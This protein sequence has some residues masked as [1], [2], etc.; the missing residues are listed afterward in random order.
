[1]YKRICILFV[2]FATLAQAQ[3]VQRNILSKQ[4]PIKNFEQF[5]VPKSSYHPYPKTIEEW[6]KLVPDSILKI[7]VKNGE[8]FLNFKF[9]PIPGSIAMEFTRTG[10]RQKQETISFKKR[11]ALFS[12]ILAESI[13]NKNRFTEAIF[14]GVWSIC[15]ES[16]WGAAAHIGG[17]GLPDPTNPVVELFSAETASVLALTDYFVGEKLDKINPQIRR[18][19]YFETNRRLLDPMLTIGGS[20]KWMS[21][22]EPVN[23][24]N[25]WII[26]NWITAILLLENDEKKRTLMAHN[27]MEGLDAYINGLGEEGGCDEGPSYWFAAGASVYD[28][29][30]IFAGA[31]NNKVK[32][33]EEPLIKKMGGYIYKMH[34][35]KNYFVNF[36]DADPTVAADGIMLYRFGKAINDQQM[37]GFGQWAFKNYPP[38]F[39]NLPTNTFSCARRIQ[40]LMSLQQMNT[41]PLPYVA[42]TAAWISDIQVLTART[43][44]GLFLATHGGHNAESHNHNDVGDF[45][46]YGNDEPIIIDAGR[47][48]YTARTF[49]SHRYELWFT[50][51]NYHNLPLVNNY[52]QSA[53]REFEATNV[54][55]VVNEKEASLSSNISAAY[56]K[57]AG[58]EKWNRLVKLDRLKNSI[59]ITDDYAI[60]ELR[61]PIQQIFM[62]VCQVDISEAG[63]IKLTTPSNQQYIIHYTPGIWSVGIEQPSTEGAEYSSFKTK[64]NNLPVQRIVCIKRGLATKGSHEFSITADKKN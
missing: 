52:G 12:L 59:S 22:T 57:E 37:I 18:R 14:N 23:N 16:F 21:K 47:G 35:G 36:S 29:L 11:G 41:S 17:T 6:K 28:C 1:M 60:K 51:S 48:N 33:F 63:K 38:S 64:W 10:D 19:I 53:G 61:I 9:E 15:E 45:I 43:N 26:S 39:S 50:Q 40:N 27:A 62:T 34:I 46:V 49:S 8:S 54:Q 44:D 56:P 5:L 3:V 4:Y 30:E 32:I 42:P 58:I 31:S 25:P 20:Y 2:L 13:E 24:W 7:V 55:A